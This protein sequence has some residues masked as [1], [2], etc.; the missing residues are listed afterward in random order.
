MSEPTEDDFDDMH[1]ALGRPVAADKI[2][3]AYRNHYCVG[4]DTKASERFAALGWWEKRGTINGGRDAMW[5]VNDA[6]KKALAKWMEVRAK[7]PTP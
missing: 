4:V 6:G 5:S 1:H 7:E 2:E 3:C